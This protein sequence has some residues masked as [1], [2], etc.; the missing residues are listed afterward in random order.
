[1][2]VPDPSTW[3]GF[4]IIAIKFGMFMASDGVELSDDAFAINFLAHDEEDDDQVH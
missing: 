1:M 4:A 3:V 2:M